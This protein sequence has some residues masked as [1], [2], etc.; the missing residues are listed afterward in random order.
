MSAANSTMT[1]PSNA[2]PEPINLDIDSDSVFAVVPRG[3]YTSDSP[4]DWMVSCCAPSAVQLAS[5]NSTGTCWQWC[6]LPQQFTNGT[7]D[8]SRGSDFLGCLTS[9]AR[10][11]NSSYMPSAALVSAAAGGGVPGQGMVG[12]GVVLLMTVSLL[13]R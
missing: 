12:L 1:C 4:D 7:S 3:N 13:F 5:D 9:T 6:D 2:V 8:S 10:A 11:T